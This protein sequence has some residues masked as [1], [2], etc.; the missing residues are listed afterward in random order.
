LW[1]IALSVHLA[2]DT[3]LSI[4][5]HAP[6]TSIDLVLRDNTG[7]VLLGW[8]TNQPAKGTWFVPGGRVQKGEH[9]DAAYVRI[10]QRET[11]LTLRREAA[12]F[13]GAYE[14][15]YAENFAE[16]SGLDTHYVVLAYQ[17][18]FESAPNVIA[19]DQHDDLRWMPI[20]DA[21]SSDDVH[22]NAKVYLR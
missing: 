11:G 2:R 8:R 20:S 21:L 6:L 14:H 9:L 5:R 10:A 15:F 3:L 16:I 13:L 19:D 17:V 1:D 12:H 7:A 18:D 4:V 22:E